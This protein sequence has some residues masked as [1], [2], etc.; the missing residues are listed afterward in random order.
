[1]PH[2]GPASN[3]SHLSSA[4]ALPCER[5]KPED[6]ALVLCACNTVQL[7]QHSR[8]PFS[9]AVPPKSPK[10]NALITRF[11]ESYSSVNMS[12]E[13]KKI[14]EIKQ[15]L[16]EFW[17]CINTAYENCNFFPVLTRSAE[18]QLLW[19]NIVKH[20][21]NVYFIGNISAK[22]YQNRF[23]C[24][25]VTANQRWDVFLRQMYKSRM[26]GYDT[27]QYDREKKANE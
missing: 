4:S 9:S 10:L 13:S 23:T 6:S 26:I 7:L 14:E 22:K 8:L 11:R 5:G 1:M 16:V 24:V 15:W 2:E 12:R 20:L 3:I 18:A 19:G 17:Q 21:L 27:I 25:K